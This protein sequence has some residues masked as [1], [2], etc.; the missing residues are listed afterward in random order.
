MQHALHLHRGE[1]APGAAGVVGVVVREHQRI[2][3]PD[4]RCAQIGRDNA[5][6][7]VRVR[8]ERRTRVVEQRAARGAHHDR[9]TLTHVERG[10]PRRR[11]G[12]RRGQRDRR[13]HQRDAERSPRKAARQEEPGDAGE[14]E[15]RRP[16]RRRMLLPG[17]RGQLRAPIQVLE[18]PLR[19]PLGEMQQRI[20]RQDRR[21]ARGA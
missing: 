9:E 7:A 16:Q 11:R 19:Q 13:R 8:T 14:R 10:D 12:R 21:D 20:H 17:R 2:E 15:Q 5:L 18:Q 6:A 3:L 1:H 4:A